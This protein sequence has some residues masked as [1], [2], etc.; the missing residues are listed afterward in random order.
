MLINKRRK[1]ETRYVKIL[2]K[3]MN[4]LRRLTRCPELAYNPVIFLRLNY[5]DL[6]TEMAKSREGTRKCVNGIVNFIFIQTVTL[7]REK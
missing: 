3:E 7:K 6:A 1:E 5:R 2:P 4:G